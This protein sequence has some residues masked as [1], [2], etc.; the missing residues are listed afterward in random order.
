MEAVFPVRS[1][2]EIYN[3]DHLSLRE[4][5]EMAVKKV[6][7]WCEMVASLRGPG[8]EESPQL[9]QLKSYSCEK[10]EAGSCGRVQFGNP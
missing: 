2:S 8:A 1:V 7:G 3:E 4:S 9:S 5:L 6:G 10:R